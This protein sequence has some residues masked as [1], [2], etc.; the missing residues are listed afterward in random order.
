MAHELAARADRDDDLVRQV[1]PQ[2]LRGLEGERLRS[3]GVEGPDVDVAE[4]PGELLQ[5]LAAEAVHVV[6]GAADRDHVRLE[7]GGRHHLPLLEVVRHEDEALEAR[8][9]GVGRHRVGQ[10]AGRR[11]ADRLEPLGSRP[12]DRHRDHPVLERVGRIHAVVLEVE[13]PESQLGAQ[14]VRLDQGREPFAERDHPGLRAHGEQVSVAPDAG[15]SGLDPGPADHPPDGVIVVFDV[16][17]TEAHL[18]DMRGLQL[19]LG[20]ALP[21]PEAEHVRHVDQSS[22]PRLKV[23]T[24]PRGFSPRPLRH[25]GGSARFLL[26]SRCPAPPRRRSG[27]GLTL[28]PQ[29][30]RV[31]A[32][33][34]AT[35]A[36]E[37]CSPNHFRFRAALWSR[38]RTPPQSGVL[39]AE[40]PL[41]ERH[42]RPDPAAAR[43][44]L[45][46][47]EKARR[48][49]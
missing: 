40:L 3:L 43:A 27:P 39:T 14:A 26:H 28:A 5:E 42:L 44:A 20:P 23:V 8:P 34:A 19:V 48:Q 47:W 9:S 15:R 36:V 24:R 25:R 30:F 13:V 2:L 21:A 37:Y 16:E 29:A 31:S 1:P 7:D 32:L 35:S 45:A 6:V 18:A 49:Q 10:V 38:S 33:P 17:G 46:A 4:G 11:T 41:L 12:G 22:G